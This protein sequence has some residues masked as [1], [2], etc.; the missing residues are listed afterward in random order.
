MRLQELWPKGIEQMQVA[1]V[2]AVV[3]A[4]MAEAGDA[5]I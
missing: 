2:A 1:A 5:K 3:V 4:A